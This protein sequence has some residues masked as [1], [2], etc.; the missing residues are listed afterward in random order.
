MILQKMPMG[1]LQDFRVEVEAM[2]SLKVTERRRELQS[3]LSKLLEI[4]ESGRKG[5]GLPMKYRNPE[6]PSEGWTGR[7]RIPLWLSARIK[8]G[9]D[10]E[11]FLIA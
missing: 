11:D 5:R 6:L 1:K 9:E 10:R 3:Q 2:I 7:G 8:A 4:H